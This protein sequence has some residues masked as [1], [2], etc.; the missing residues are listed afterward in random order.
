MFDLQD[1]PALGLSDACFVKQQSFHSNLV[2]SVFILSTAYVQKVTHNTATV[3]GA[4]LV[5]IWKSVP[6]VF[7]DIIAVDIF[8]K[9]LPKET[10]AGNDK[11]ELFVEASHARTISLAEGGLGLCFHCPCHSAT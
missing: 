10:G 9:G 11:D 5:H 8:E 7:I 2:F 6:L 4:G 1:F 3:L